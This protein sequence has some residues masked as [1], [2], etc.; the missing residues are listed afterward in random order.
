MGISAKQQRF[1]EEYCVDLNASQAAL[2]AGYS[3]KTSASQ[4]GRL[5]QNVEIKRAIMDR[6]ERR[7]ADVNVTA[8][9]VLHKLIENAEK[10]AQAIPV[11][12]KK[13][14]PTGE[15]TYYPNAVNRALELIGK[16]MGM[17]PD[18]VQHSGPGGGAIPV[19]VEVSE[20][21]REYAGIVRTVNSGTDAG[22]VPEVPSRDGDREPV[23][24]APTNG[25]TG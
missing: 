2:R 20:T 1:V 7:S 11:L 21:L 25:E 9:W 17:F 3:S 12:D 8:D 14:E 18:K 5:L 6:N 10:A 16:H 13:G 23:D 4:G 15:Y 24:T 19:K 22:N